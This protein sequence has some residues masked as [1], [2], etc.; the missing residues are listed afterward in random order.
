M[1]PGDD[2]WDRLSTL[3]ERCLVSVASAYPPDEQGTPR[4]RWTVR[5]SPLGSADASELVQ[6]ESSSLFTAMLAAMN[7]ARVKGWVE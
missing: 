3:H 6:S 7:L 5:L 1:A 2:F 4:L